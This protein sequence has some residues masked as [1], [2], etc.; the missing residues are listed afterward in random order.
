M[1]NLHFKINFAQL[2]SITPIYIDFRGIAIPL[3]YRILNNKKKKY[4]RVAVVK[5]DL[6]FLGC[7]E[8]L[9]KNQFAVIFL[10]RKLETGNGIS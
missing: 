8:H 10:R 2:G 5:I 9:K 3:T 7:T 1:P 4:Y 6:R